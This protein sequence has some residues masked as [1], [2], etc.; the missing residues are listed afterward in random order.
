MLLAWAA[1]SKYDG[2]V[3]QGPWPSEQAEGQP[4]QLT[5]SARPRERY[6][7]CSVHG[8]GAGATAAVL[9]NLS[10]RELGAAQ[11]TDE[12]VAARK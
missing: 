5:Y 7:C 2:V 6:V 3:E 4:A 1:F 12:Q 10:E 9:H 8:M 11:Q